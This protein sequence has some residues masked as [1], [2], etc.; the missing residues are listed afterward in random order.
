M[1]CFLCGSKLELLEENKGWYQCS[2]VGCNEVFYFKKEKD[3]ANM[4]LQI[5]PFTVI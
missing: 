2:K 5:T 1:Y 4:I 3:I